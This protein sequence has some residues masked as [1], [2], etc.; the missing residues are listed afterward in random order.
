MDWI[1]E[2]LVPPPTASRL[3]RR[4]LRSIYYGKGPS[5]NFEALVAT[6][7]TEHSELRFLK[8]V[9]RARPAL[10]PLEIDSL[11]L[12]SPVTRGALALA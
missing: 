9:I 8:L 3:E 7:S 4:A 1:I 11:S 10:Q 6:A 5:I 2:R 12:T